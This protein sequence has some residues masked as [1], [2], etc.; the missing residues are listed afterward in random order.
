VYY[1]AV[2]EEE[3]DGFFQLIPEGHRLV[4]YLQIERH[5]L[6]RVFLTLAGKCGAGRD[7]P[8]LAEVAS[9]GRSRNRGSILCQKG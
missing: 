7:P 4:M 2:S 6:L 5:K 8:V 3:S 9:A 1:S